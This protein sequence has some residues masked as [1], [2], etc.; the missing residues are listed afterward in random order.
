MGNNSVC[1]LWPGWVYHSPF[2]EIVGNNVGGDNTP[3]DPNNEE[4]ACMASAHKEG[5]ATGE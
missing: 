3:L 5:I 2:P 1:Q 4:N